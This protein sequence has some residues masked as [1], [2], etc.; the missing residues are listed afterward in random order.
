MCR[1][2]QCKT[3]SQN[4]RQRINSSPVCRKVSTVLIQR[5]TLKRGAYLVAGTAWAKV[6]NEEKKERDIRYEA[7]NRGRS[8]PDT[9]AFLS[10]RNA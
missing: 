4:F 7:P 1:C 8:T 3:N 5:G 10:L 9:F 6:Y 2:C